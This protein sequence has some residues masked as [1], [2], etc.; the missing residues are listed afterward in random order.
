MQKME[1]LANSGGRQNLEIKIC[2]F[3]NLFT[4][5]LLVDHFATIFMFGHSVIETLRGIIN[6]NASFNKCSYHFHPLPS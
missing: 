6:P 3:K 5:L 1:N 4:V 2:K